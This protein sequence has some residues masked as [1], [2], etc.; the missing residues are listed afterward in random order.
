MQRNF[1]SRLAAFA[2][3]CCCWLING[4]QA[5]AQFY[6]HALGVRAGTSFQASYKFFLF[7]QPTHIQQAVEVLG[8]VHFDVR[9]KVKN[10]YVFEALYNVHIDVGFD[11]GFS[12]FAGAGFFTGVYVETGQPN[13]WGGGVTAALGME[14]TFTHVPINVAI[15]WRPFL[16]LPR[17]SLLSTALTVRYVFPTTWQ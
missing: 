10:G 14:Y 9:N 2:L 16:G 4:T 8:G 12:A 1:I 11:T 3:F 5:R 15:D 17:S 7:Y 6:D 13:V